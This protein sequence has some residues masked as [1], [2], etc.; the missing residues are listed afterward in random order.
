ME[1]D[2]EQI[3]QLKLPRSKTED[4]ISWLHEKSGAYSV[5]S[6]YKLA[7]DLQSEEDGTRQMSLSN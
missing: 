3:F 5:K 4:F 6:A 2:A 1:H 7:R